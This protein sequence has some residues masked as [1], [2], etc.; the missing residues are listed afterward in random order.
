[1]VVGGVGGNSW[2]EYWGLDIGDWILGMHGERWVV[3]RY[4][5]ES[6]VRKT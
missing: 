3:L 4:A 1:M 6:D 2:G 5:G